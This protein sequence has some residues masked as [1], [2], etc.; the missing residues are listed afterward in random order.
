VHTLENIPPA[1][2]AGRRVHPLVELRVD[3]SAFEE[4]ERR[5]EKNGP[6]GN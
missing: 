2:E 3:R 1:A 4:L 6:W 5:L